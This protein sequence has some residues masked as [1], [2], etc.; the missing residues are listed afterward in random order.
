MTLR[1]QL[2]HLSATNLFMLHFHGPSFVL[3]LDLVDHSQSEA[4]TA[5]TPR[6]SVP[7]GAGAGASVH[8]HLSASSTGLVSP[9]LVSQM[10]FCPQSVIFFK[11]LLSKFRLTIQQPP[12]RSPNMQTFR[13][14]SRVERCCFT[15]SVI[16]KRTRS[17]PLSVIGDPTGVCSV[18]RSYTGG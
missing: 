1:F 4:L 12:Y 8:A 5:S 15:L 18:D 7:I 2:Y 3:G 11:A 10:T 17:L 14:T 13:G 16:A 9:V 6:L